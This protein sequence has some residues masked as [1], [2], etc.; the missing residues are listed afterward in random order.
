MRTR[1][2][3]YRPSN[4]ENL[5]L[6]FQLF[7]F[8]LHPTDESWNDEC[9]EPLSVSTPPCNCCPAPSYRTSGSSY[10]PL[11]LCCLPLLHPRGASSNVGC[12]TTAHSARGW[13][14]VHRPERGERRGDRDKLYA[15]CF[16][17]NGHSSETPNLQSALL[18][19][20]ILFTLH[21]HNLEFNAT[22][23]SHPCDSD[24][25]LR[26]GSRGSIRRCSVVL[27]YSNL[28]ALF[29]G[30]LCRRK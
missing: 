25:E 14:A 24:Y 20:H 27:K 1:S 8:D 21:D 7:G 28:R 30:T 19:T 12:L 23:L 18:A 13:C 16:S 5:I 9:F 11:P 10:L 17:N 26:G 4:C 15:A 29:S 2:V 3:R 22:W 6:W